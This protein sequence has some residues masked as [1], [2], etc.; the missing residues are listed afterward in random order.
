MSTNWINSELIQ[1]TINS[2]LLSLSKLKENFNKSK[3]SQKVAILALFWIL[4][5]QEKILWMILFKIQTLF[6]LELKIC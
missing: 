1:L 2:R 6:K 3:L 4:K 5:S